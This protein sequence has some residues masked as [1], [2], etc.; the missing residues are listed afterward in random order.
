MFFF[1]QTTMESLVLQVS[2]VF[3]MFLLHFGVGLS[4]F[5]LVRCCD[6]GRQSSELPSWINCVTGGVFIA[7][8]FLGL[9]PYA[10]DKFDETDFA[11]VLPMAQIFVVAGVFFVL[12]LESAVR[13][14]LFRG[15]VKT[16]QASKASTVFHDVLAVDIYSEEARDAVDP[17]ME[18]SPHSDEM[19]VHVHGGVSWDD[20]LTSNSPNKDSSVIFLFMAINLH[21][22]F[23]GVALGLQTEPKKL[24]PLFIG[25][26]VHEIMTSFALGVSV[27]RKRFPFVTVAK[28]LFSFA[29]SIPLGIPQP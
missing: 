15:G 19:Q 23:E 13:L 25:I 10:E 21:A 28:Y 8:C 20:I 9:I 27:V 24:V 29:A 12:L 5:L 16:H 7:M 6:K 18:E 4:P 26:L 22:F 17:L 14:W 1:P 2:C 11:S 3:L